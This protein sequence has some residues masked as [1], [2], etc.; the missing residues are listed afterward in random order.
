MYNY[1]YYFSSLWFANCEFWIYTFYLYSYKTFRELFIFISVSRDP[2]LTGLDSH[3]GSTK[4]LKWEYRGMA[5]GLQTLRLALQ[6][7][8]CLKNKLLLYIRSS[9]I[10]MT[11]HRRDDVSINGNFIVCSIARSN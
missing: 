6:G 11:S 2:L 10:E 9:G 7:W 5:A 3:N 1:K 8:L 4:F